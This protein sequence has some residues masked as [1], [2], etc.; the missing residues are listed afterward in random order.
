MAKKV[1]RSKVDWWIRVLLGLVIVGQFVAIGAIVLEETD[2]VAITVTILFCLA[3]LALFA[4]V[5][6][7]TAYTV[8]RG[9]LLVR[10]G[11]VRWKVPLDSITAVEATRS[12]WS[13]PALSLDRLRIRYG[14]RRQVLVSPADKAGFLEAIGWNPQELDE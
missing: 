9:M 12:P 6:L 5:L 11:P 10:S 3:G 13:S 4:W 2:P 8:E 14:E 1:F 7:G